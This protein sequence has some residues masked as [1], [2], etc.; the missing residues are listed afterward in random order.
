M[1]KNDEENEKTENILADFLYHLGLFVLKTLLWAIFI[2][3]LIKMLQ[4]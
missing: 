4:N 2:M 1:N 3:Y